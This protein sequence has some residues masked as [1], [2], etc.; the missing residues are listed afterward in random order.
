MAVMI[1]TDSCPSARI[2]AVDGL[3]INSTSSPP[4]PPFSDISPRAQASLPTKNV[5]IGVMFDSTSR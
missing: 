4:R 3:T 5:A 2:R 1:I